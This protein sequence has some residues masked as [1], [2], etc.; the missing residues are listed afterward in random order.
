MKAPPVGMMATIMAIHRAACQ[1]VAVVEW[2]IHPPIRNTC[3]HARAMTTPA[4]IMKR[5]VIHAAPRVDMTTATTIPPQAGVAAHLAA[6]SGFNIPVEEAPSF[7]L[8]TVALDR[9]ALR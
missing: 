4:L 7:V 5:H 9:A 8:I 1:P 2:T 6:G 3:R